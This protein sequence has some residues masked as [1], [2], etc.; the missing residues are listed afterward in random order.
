MI[1]VRTPS[2]NVVLRGT[3]PRSA[4]PRVYDLPAQRVS[5]HLVVSTWDLTH[6]ER[7]AIAEGALIELYVWSLTPHPPVSLEI[8]QGVMRDAGD[9]PAHGGRT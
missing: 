3:Q 1:P 9:P 5:E 6:D 2:T 4:E 7:I 8:A